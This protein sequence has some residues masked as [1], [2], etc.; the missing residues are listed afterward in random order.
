MSLKTATGRLALAILVAAAA[1]GAAR[2]EPPADG[3]KTPRTERH[4]WERYR[5]SARTPAAQLELA[6][7]LRDDGRLIRASKAFLALVNAWPDAAEAPT[8]QLAYCRLLERRGK[9][10]K[11]FEEYEIL[12]RAYAG[13][14]PYDE[15]LE[16]MYAIADATAA[17]GRN[18]L[19][20]KVDAPEDA[21]P[22]FESL[23]QNGQ[24]WKR[25]PEL[26]FRIAR[27]YAKNEQYD[28]AMDA[29]GLYYQ[30]YPLSPLAEQALFG[31]A[32]CAERLAR[33]YPVAADLHE[34]AAALFQGFID[35]YPYSAMTP[36]AR[37][38]LA[39]LQ[40]DLSGQLFR[41]AGLYHKTAGFTRDPEQR[42]ARLRAAR[43]GYERVI[44]EY[45]S[46][47]WS[48]QAQARLAGLR[49]QQEAVP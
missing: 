12:V 4:W 38:L 48:D 45:P 19:G 28:L 20:F 35:W 22:M 44:D 18:V 46:S 31:Q 10:R 21:I 42:Q 7:R 26:Q 43:L 37:D 40:Q 32:T 39:G 16:R 5:P 8:A 11:A 14:F 41:Q 29:Y 27:I 9:P 13:F 25:A 49:R 30:R 15:V 6:N 36:N 47:A 1:V 33:Q 24:Q 2:T 3:A 34:N 17:S 23:I